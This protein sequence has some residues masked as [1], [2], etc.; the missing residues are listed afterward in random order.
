M[1]KE[2]NEEILHEIENHFKNFANTYKFLNIEIRNNQYF[3]FVKC[4][5]EL[6]NPYWVSWQHFKNRNDRCGK[7]RYI[8]NGKK[9]L[10]YNKEKI[11][12]IINNT[13]YKLIKIN[14]IGD[15]ANIIISTEEGYLINT[16]LNNINKKKIIK[17]NPFYFKNIYTIDNIKLW[18][19]IHKKSFELISTKYLNNHDL[20]KW[21]CL[22]CGHD[23]EISWSYIS[24]Y[25]YKCSY[26][27]QIRSLIINNLLIKNPNLS[28][29][30]NYEKNYPICPEDILANTTKA[31]WWICENCKYEWIKSVHYRN[32]RNA[33][34]PMCKMSKGE[35][36]IKC[37]L[38]DN[39]ILYNYEY[40]FNNCIN[41][42]KLRFDFYI[43]SHNIC[44]EY[45]GEFHYKKIIGISTDLSLEKQK[46]C[47]NIKKIFCTN[48]NIKLLEIPY[49]NFKNINKILYQNLIKI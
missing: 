32:Q 40:S 18:C 46:K 45:Q 43:K 27:S 34:C 9:S 28:K 25:S 33:P 44:I 7:C 15:E 24:N 41:N 10:K 47:D 6:H 23:F 20:L 17:L 4:D 37:F 30:W 42:K 29:Q 26:C 38:E 19:K 14:S 49:W 16:F 11:E 36:S 48:N 8:N 21:K 12:E 1:K 31:Y 5:S 2:I 22:K 39:N 35:Y 13:E 3:I